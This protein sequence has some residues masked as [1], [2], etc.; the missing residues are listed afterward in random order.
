MNE[1]CTHCRRWLERQVSSSGAAGATRAVWLKGRRRQCLPAPWAKAGKY[2]F[3]VDAPACILSPKESER[4]FDSCTW[5][6]CCIKHAGATVL[7]KARTTDH[8]FWIEL[9]QPVGAPGL[10]F[11]TIF[12]MGRSFVDGPVWKMRF[13]DFN[14]A[15]YG[16]IEGGNICE[17]AAQF[18][19]RMSGFAASAH[20]LRW[21]SRGVQTPAE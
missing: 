17:L 2:I 3:I 12:H 14:A 19:D 10:T 16:Q 13:F 8:T 7:L 1:S 6:C 18:R 21:S 15:L 5:V 11:R 20:D 9:V 4:E